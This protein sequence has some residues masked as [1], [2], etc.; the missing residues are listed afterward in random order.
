MQTK[1]KESGV[2][3][4]YR[5]VGTIKMGE[6]RKEYRPSIHGKNEVK[7]QIDDEFYLCRQHGAMAWLRGKKQRKDLLHGEADR[8]Q[9]GDGLGA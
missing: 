7:W 2:G 9:F 8:L 5:G 4:I 3:R 6:K 1:K